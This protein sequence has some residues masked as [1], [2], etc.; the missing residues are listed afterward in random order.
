[1]LFHQVRPSPGRLGQYGRQYLLDAGIWSAQ[2]LVAAN[3][4]RRRDVIR[5]PLFT[6]SDPTVAVRN[7]VG[8][9]L[10]VRYDIINLAAFKFEY[11]HTRRNPTDPIV[12]GLFFQTSFTF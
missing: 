3:T 2:P 6:V 12:N 5:D 8:S 9:T 7:L 4:E 1:M 11:R 10:G